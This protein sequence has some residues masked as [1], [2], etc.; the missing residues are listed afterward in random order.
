MV[1]EEFLMVRKNPMKLRAFSQ[2]SNIGQRFARGQTPGISSRLFTGQTS[3][4]GARF[5]GGPTRQPQFRIATGKEILRRA[6][7]SG[8]GAQRT[9]KGGIRFAKKTQRFVKKTQKFVAK[10]KQK[11]QKAIQAPRQKIVQTEKI[12]TAKQ[13]KRQLGQPTTE[14]IQKK[15]AETKVQLP[16]T[17]PTQVKMPTTKNGQTIKKSNNKFVRA[18]DRAIAGKF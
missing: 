8:R 14:F 5:A 9:I 3:G 7:K 11:P 16:R 6:T 1:Q 18:F 2:K 17:P 10:Q 15:R 12:T 13:L 4:L